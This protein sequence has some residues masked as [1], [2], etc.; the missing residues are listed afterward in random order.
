MGVVVVFPPCHRLLLRQI[1]ACDGIAIDRGIG[2]G[3]QRQ[4][5]RDIMREDAAIGL[6]QLEKLYPGQVM[7]VFY[8]EYVTQ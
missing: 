4:G 2:E 8:T 5:S 7:G 3:R 6:G 1:P